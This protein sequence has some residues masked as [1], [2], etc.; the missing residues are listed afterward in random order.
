L[1]PLRAGCL[2]VLL[3]L[4]A[5]PLR[6]QYG[7]PAKKD[8][9][10]SAQMAPHAVCPWLSVGSAGHALD[11]DVSVTANVANLSE[12]SC[13]FSRQAGVADSLE[14]V[15]GKA[16]MPGCPAGAAEL[17]GI[18]NEALR[19]RMPGSRSEAEMISSR[20][21]DVPFA[22]ILSL[23]GQKKAQSPADDALEQVAEQVAGNLY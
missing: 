22:I 2:V 7:D 14:I 18:G 11:G 21:R 1:S 16:A 10:P 6:A 15:V 12:G 4:A 8:V 19:C 20:V 13:K 23:H 9:H 17:R 3:L 5:A